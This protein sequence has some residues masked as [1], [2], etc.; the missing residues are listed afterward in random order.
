[1]G[2]LLPWSHYCAVDLLLVFLTSDEDGKNGPFHSWLLV[3]ILLVP[4]QQLQPWVMALGKWHPPSLTFPL[5]QA[6]VEV[7]CSVRGSRGGVKGK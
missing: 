4:I 1:M 2:F 3:E 7:K 6:M 5:P